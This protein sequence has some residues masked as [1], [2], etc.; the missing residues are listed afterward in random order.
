MRLSQGA[1]APNECTEQKQPQGARKY[2]DVQG[3]EQRDF[4][5]PER[6]YLA[7]AARCINLIGLLN[8]T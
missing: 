4:T 6:Q 3:N 1:A 8:V 7:E 2:V 5:N